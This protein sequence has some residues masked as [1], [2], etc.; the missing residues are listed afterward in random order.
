MI[1]AEKITELRK[2]AG[3]SQEQLAEAVGVSRQ[4]ISKWESAQSIPDMNKILALSKFFGV[5]TDY[6]LKDELS[7]STPAETSGE[8]PAVDSKGETLIPVS[9][10]TAASFL[11]LAKQSAPKVAGAVMLCIFSPIPLILLTGASTDGTLPMTEDQSSYLGLIL[12]MLMVAAAVAVFISDSLKKKK[13][14]F[15]QK[16]AIDT[17]YGIEGMVKERR[18]KFESAHTHEIITGILLCVLSCLP[19]FVTGAFGSWVFHSPVRMSAE[20]S[21][22]AVAG[23][24]MLL[25][26]VGIGVFFLVKT[27]IVWQSFDALLEEGNYTRTAK[28]KEREIGGIYWGIVTAG[29][30]LVSFLTMRWDITWVV[31]PVAGVLYGVIS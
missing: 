10:D 2:K 21:L 26:L 5:S 27:S 4:A 6:L 23:V 16:E 3:L 13:Y 20:N 17:E 7:E 28:R 8:E 19:I 25:L 31:W 18:A 9:M 15:L 22:I 14:E 24:A 30:L 12:L 11:S 29:Y 1:L